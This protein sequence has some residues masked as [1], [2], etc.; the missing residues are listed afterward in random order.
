MDKTPPFDL[1]QIFERMPWAAMVRSLDTNAIVVV[2]REFERI[3]GYR[4]AEVLGKHPLEIGLYPNEDDFQQKVSEL[5]QAGKVQDRVI[6]LRKK[7]GEI[8]EATHSAAVVPLFKQ[9]FIVVVFR[10]FK[11]RT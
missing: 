10:D 1:A 9:A 6:L 4:R 7:D 2:N 8:L 5:A 3:S 11:A